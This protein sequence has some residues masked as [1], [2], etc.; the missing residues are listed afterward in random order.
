ASQ[1]EGQYI[2]GMV[3]IMEHTMAMR[4]RGGRYVVL[5]KAATSETWWPEHADH[6]AF[7]RGRIGF[8]VPTWFKPA[9]AQQV[10]TGAFFAGAIAVFDKTWA[11]PAMGY[12]NRD[13]LIARGETALAQ[14]RWMAP[15]FVQPQIQTPDIDPVPETAN[16]VWPAEVYFLFDQVPAAGSLPADLQNKIRSHINHM[17]LDGTPTDAIIQQTIKLTAAMGATA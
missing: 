12:V 17:K 6:I 9:D 4:E 13:D 2:T 1:H 15:R 10:P 3:H 8:D 14:M 11:G 5:I 7:I 16:R